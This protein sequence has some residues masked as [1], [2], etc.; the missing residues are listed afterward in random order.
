V[1][2]SEYRRRFELPAASS[3][4]RAVDALAEDELI[5][6]GPGGDY[7]IAEPFLREWVLAYGS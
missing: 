6:R 3:V 1:F 5:A 7:A 2:S 4:Q